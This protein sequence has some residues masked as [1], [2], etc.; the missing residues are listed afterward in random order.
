MFYFFIYL[1]SYL[2][3]LDPVFVKL[4]GRDWGFTTIHPLWNSGLFGRI[5]ELP[6]K[7]TPDQS[8]SS[9]SPG[10]CAA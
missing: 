5:Q 8:E 4:R 7:D 10:L 1:F 9:V 2:Q 6:L 3:Q